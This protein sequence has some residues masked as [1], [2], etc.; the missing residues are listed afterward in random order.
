[1]CRYLINQRWFEYLILVFIA[2]NCITLAME[3]PHIPADSIVKEL[4]F[5]V[6]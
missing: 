5:Y 2:L 4:D 1:M 3:R 6:Y